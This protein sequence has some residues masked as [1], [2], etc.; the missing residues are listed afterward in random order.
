[1]V[2][3]ENENKQGDLVRCFQILDTVSQALSE[4]VQGGD[5][6]A[7]T[8]IVATLNQKFA[9][10]EKALDGLPGGGMT[11]EEQIERID[12]LRRGLERKR[13]LVKAYRRHDLVA[14]VLHQRAIPEVTC[15][16]A[17]DEDMGGGEE[18]DVEDEE[19]IGDGDGEDV[20]V[21]L[22]MDFG[23]GEGLAGGDGEDVMMGLEIN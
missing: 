23:V 8:P 15:G 21:D 14:R 6:K 12:E 3:D 4:I 11:H 10:C 18:V 9:R 20:G 7:L 19:E 2:A 22:D 1:M 5:A 16:G 13:G 17:G